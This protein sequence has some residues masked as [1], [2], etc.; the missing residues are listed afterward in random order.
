MGAM[1]VALL[2]TGVMGSGMA[3]SLLWSGHQVTVWNRSRAK[4]EPLAED[5]ARVVGDA[6]EAA[7]GAEAV[8][9]VL[10]DAESVVEV[11]SDVCPAMPDG[12]VW[13]QTSTVG[14]E[15]AH[16]AGRLA[17]E[18]GVP[19]VDAPV[20]GTRKPAAEG[21]LVVL[22]AGRNDL[23]DRVQPVLD[24]IGSRTVWVSERVGDGSALKLACN[25]W[26]SA[27][28]AATGQSIALARALG[29]DPQLFLE[30][31]RGGPTDSAYAHL[32]GGAM[33]SG[34]FPVQ[35][36]LDG[37]VKDVGLIREAA[38]ATGVSPLLLDGVLASFRSASERG[39]GAED[40]AAVVAAFAP[41]PAE[42][43]R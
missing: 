35:F 3:R 39:H 13:L 32:K 4:A 9:T 23:R 42:A 43:G 11:M 20:L 1:R 17:A 25:A 36:A 6:P 22:A 27:I 8:L 12:A 5:G 21:K 30:A 38:L 7:V 29:L 31:I 37:V 41:H 26:V 19:M 14:T 33:I 2:G 28:T 40:M 16:R 24:A 18:H 34:D 15:G 10:Y